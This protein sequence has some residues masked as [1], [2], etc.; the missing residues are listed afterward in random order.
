M[1]TESYVRELL[2]SAKRKARITRS[3][4]GLNGN[5]RLL[6]MSMCTRNVPCFC[7]SAFV[8]FGPNHTNCK[9]FWNIMYS[10]NA[11]KPHWCPWTRKAP[12]GNASLTF[13]MLCTELYLVGISRECECVNC[14]A[15]FNLNFS[16]SGNIHVRFA[17]GF[18]AKSHSGLW[19]WC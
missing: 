12:I 3:V 13:W 14:E 16:G 19:G 7:C 2:G 11:G 9:C 17:P 6:Y 10:C 15:L 4:V 5:A 1:E 18:S 8:F